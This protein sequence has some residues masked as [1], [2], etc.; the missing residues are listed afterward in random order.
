SERNDWLTHINSQLSNSSVSTTSDSIPE[1]EVSASTP[2]TS[3]FPPSPS[4]HVP[5]TTISSQQ[6]QQQPPMSSS[7][8]EPTTVLPVDH[9]AIL[10]IHLEQCRGMAAADPYLIFHVGEHVTRTPTLWRCKSE[11]FWSQSFEVMFSSL[12]DG[13]F[14]IPEQVRLVLLDDRGTGEPSNDHV[15]G[16]G[17]VPLAAALAE[18]RASPSRRDIIFFDSWLRLRPIHKSDYLAGDLLVRTS[19]VPPNPSLSRAQGTLSVTVIAGRGLPATAPSPHVVVGWHG[20]AECHKSP[21][22]RKAV[23]PVWNFSAQLAVS[24]QL[25]E[26]P[27]TSFNVF[28]FDGPDRLGVVSLKLA[29]LDQQGDVQE[30]WHSLVKQSLNAHF[31]TPRLFPRGSSS[32]SSSLPRRSASSSSTSTSTTSTTPSSSQPTHED[33]HL[34][35]ETSEFSVRQTSGLL[36]KLGSSATAILGGSSTSGPAWRSVS[37]GAAAAGCGEVKLRLTWSEFSVY[38]SECYDQLRH[39]LFDPAMPLVGPLEALFR[40]RL[41]DDLGA[42]LARISSATG[43][44][45]V[46]ISSLV[47]REIRTASD[48]DV[49][50]RA[51]SLASKALDQYQKLL[52]H[53]YLARCVGPLVGKILTRPACECDPSAIPGGDKGVVEKNLARLSRYARQVARN[54]LDSQALIPPEL[55]VVYRAIREEATQLQL[56]H[57]DCRMNLVHLSVSSFFFLR[58]I[59]PAILNP[60]LFGLA[61]DHPSQ[62]ANRTCTYLAKVLQTA[63]NLVVFKDFDLLSPLNA[64]VGDLSSQIQKFIAQISAPQKPVFSEKTSID[65]P[66]YLEK[67]LC[68]LSNMLSNI[69]E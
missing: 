47:V 63:A 67:D 3:T 53:T 5:S 42:I 50:F 52:S 18:L 7:P 51:N 61:S 57:P 24:L 20:S 66:L 23:D 39:D 30:A 55:L 48:P 40:M 41:G 58:L 12:K 35:A 16:E 56:A 68:L 17:T 4:S 14:S 64:L 28:L 31:V 45:P 32:S 46:L 8:I 65:H 36:S 37:A 62:A 69:E 6:Q 22:V 49:L 60:K 10:W 15:L 43:Q 54:I 13:G 2:S 25:H 21:A 27:H 29:R 9:V 11:G 34:T 44:G 38:P 19:Y 33:Q 26:H 1:T 59:C